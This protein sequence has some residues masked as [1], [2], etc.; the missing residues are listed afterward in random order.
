MATNFLLQPINNSYLDDSSF[1][2]PRYTSRKVELDEDYS[3]SV[4]NYLNN[5]TKAGL[6]KFSIDWLGYGGIS[7]DVISQ[8]SRKKK[9]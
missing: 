4:V 1:V 9:R 5:P 2:Y 7:R 6:W 8:L 3:A